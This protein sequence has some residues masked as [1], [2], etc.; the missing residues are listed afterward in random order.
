MLVRVSLDRIC[1]TLPLL[2]SV[3]RIDDMKSQELCVDK[4]PCSVARV[5][6][7]L[8]LDVGLSNSSPSGRPTTRLWEREM[9]Q[10]TQ[11]SQKQ[12]LIPC[13]SYKRYGQCSYVRSSFIL[14]E[15]MLLWF[16]YEY[17]SEAF[18]SFY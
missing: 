3:S 8:A 17:S 18:F 9:Q 10:V 15:R 13:P 7:L 2:T 5:C 14:M 6:V 12:N 11:V 4:G 1:L 16:T